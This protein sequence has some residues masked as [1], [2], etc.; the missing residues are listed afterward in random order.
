MTSNSAAETIAETIELQNPYTVGH[1][2]RVTN[3]SDVIG[4]YMGMNPQELEN[5]RLSAILH[6]VGKIGVR[7]SVLLKPDGLNEEELQEMK[8]HPDYGAEVLNHIKQL[9]DVIP[10]VRGH[11]ERYDGHGYPAGL[12]NV[13]IP[14]TAKIIS[15]ADAFDAMTTDRPYRK[16]LSVHAALDEL[17][18]CS[19]T[20]F[21]PEVVDA[22]LV[23]WNNGQL[24]CNGLLTQSRKSITFD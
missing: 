5:L 15:V 3:Y 21:A 23:V 22:F 17:T 2:R 19:G 13:E 7:D 16:G 9:K 8:R 11:H 18:W 4:R 24:N 1:A 14:I 20:Q 12:K 6:D 10:G